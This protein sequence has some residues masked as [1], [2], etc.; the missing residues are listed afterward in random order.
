MQSLPSRIV[1]ISALILI[2]F[3]QFGCRKMASQNPVDTFQDGQ[4]PKQLESLRSQIREITVRDRE[5]ILER[6]AKDQNNPNLLKVAVIDSGVDIAH[7][8]LL[9]QLDYRVENGRIVGA[10]FDLMGNAQS[11][12][13]VYVNPNLFAFASD[14]LRKGK[15]TGVHQAPLEFIKKMEDRLADLIL[16]EMQKDPILMASR[17]SKINRNSLQ[18]LQLAELVASMKDNLEYYEGNK[19]ENSLITDAAFNN[20][21]ESFDNRELYRLLD[22]E[23][24]PLV[25]EIETSIFKFI[26]QVEHADRFFKI[27]ENAFEVIEKEFQYTKRIKR[28]VEFMKGGGESIDSKD[29]VKELEAAFRYTQYGSDAFDPILKLK[30]YFSHIREYAHLPLGVALSTYASELESRYNEV[31]KKKNLEPEQRRALN[32]GIENLKFYR[33]MAK[34]IQDLEKDP[35]AYKKFRS[36][37]RRY[38]HRTQ[39]PFLL[40]ESNGNSH[41][42]HVAATIAKQNPNI[43]IVPI[44]VTTSGVVA[45]QDRFEAVLNQLSSDFDQWLKIPIVQELMTEIKKE[46]AGIQISETTIRRGFVQYFKKNELNALFITEVLKAIEVVGSQN[47]KL[48]NVSLGTNFEKD[49]KIKKR[50]DSF[51]V[52][53]VAEFVRYRMGQTMLEKAPHTLFLIA[54]GNDNAWFDGVTRSAFPVG[55]RSMRLQKISDEKGIAHS[56]NNKTNNVVGVASVNPTGSLTAFTNFSIQKDFPQIF[57]TGEEIMAAVPP[58]N[59]KPVEDLIGKY[60]LRIEVAT[61][62]AKVIELSEALENNARYDMV[63]RNEAEL[64]DK[65][66]AASVET[67]AQ[68]LHFN[69]PIT[70]QAMSGTSMATPTVTGKLADSIIKRSI[71]T[72]MP[73]KTHFAS[74]ELSPEV[75]AQDLL[76]MAKP[77]PYSKYMVVEV[78]TL[79]DKIQKWPTSKG[80]IA[81]DKAIKCLKVVSKTP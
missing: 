23:W 63:A 32:A 74:R 75:L 14:G 68:M 31:L 20:R 36:G 60:T 62:T 26:Y 24:R 67:L 48:A 8:D 11:G 2:A 78:K 34:S 57:S 47:I 79:V 17:F 66:L 4:F 43:R 29:V 46:Y 12:T 3:T 25:G 81:T 77:G 44:R 71:L 45:A 72:N 70:R 7:P 39:H 35:E 40:S 5:A 58:K 73:V 50:V 49:H 9:G 54:T 37:L 27:V 38:V 30:S 22:T 21:P 53:L 59:T 42:T 19:K 61:A 41:G 6:I 13:H 56:P 80:E 55:I 18:F 76:A 10:G 64:K 28:T 69:S 16:S 52:D 65:A 33:S 1:L 15:I 51:I